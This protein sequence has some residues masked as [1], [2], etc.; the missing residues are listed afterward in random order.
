M[1]LTQN[2]KV[3]IKCLKKCGLEKQMIIVLMIALRNNQDKMNQVADYLI[4]QEKNNTL[5][6]D[7]I[8]RQVME[9]AMSKTIE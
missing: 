2:Q 6:S 8:A 7:Q 9:I 3:L 4:E 1:E 5:D